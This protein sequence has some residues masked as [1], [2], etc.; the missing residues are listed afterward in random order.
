[1]DDR[2]LEQL[3]TDLQA[4]KAQVSGP[5]AQ[6]GDRLVNGMTLDKFIGMTLGSAVVADRIFV[7]EAGYASLAKTIPLLILNVPIT[8]IGDHRQLP[9]VCEA[10]D[11]ISKAF[12]EMPSIFI[13]DAFRIA[14]TETPFQFGELA[15]LSEPTL[16]LETV[17]LKK[18]FRFGNDLAGLLNEFVYK[19]G[20]EGNDEHEMRIRCVHCQSMDFPVSWAPKCA[21]AMRY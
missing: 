14:E 1:M 17:R 10:D 19:F 5:V 12:W 3:D 15:N 9:P 18:S 4:A 16:G 21:N 2:T 11:N 7:D 6:T 13:R 20:F 8:F